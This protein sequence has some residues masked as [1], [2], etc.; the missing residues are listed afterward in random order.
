MVKNS[1]LRPIRID[2]KCEWSLKNDVRV[3]IQ[4]SRLITKS[5]DVR[6]RDSI[7][8]IVIKVTGSHNKSCIVISCYFW[9]IIHPKYSEL[10]FSSRETP[11]S[12][13]LDKRKRVIGWDTEV[14]YRIYELLGRAKDRD[15]VLGGLKPIVVDATYS[16]YSHLVDS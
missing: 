4:T 1:K 10:T 12:R 14:G 15:P 5:F 9:N 7:T 11:I 8:F 2:S 13:V 3:I 16:H 6:K